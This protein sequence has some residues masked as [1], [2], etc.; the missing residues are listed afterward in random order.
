MVGL[1]G[2]GRAKY[3]TG[4]RLGTSAGLGWKGLL[5]ER[6]TH[7]EGDL[8]EVEPRD[9][10]VIV[11]LRGRLHVRRR[12]DG[13]LEHRDSGPGSV[14]LCPAGVREDMIHLYGKVRESVHLYLP[15]MPLSATAL[16]EIDADLRNVAVQYKGGFRDPLVERVARAVRAEMLDPAPGGKLLVETLAAALGVHILRQHANL[17]HSP[18]PS[19]R[20][21]LDCRRLQRVVDFIEAR[22]GEDLTI[23]ALA[24]EA[25][26]SPFHFARAFKAATG[27]A[28]HRYLLDRRI[29][30]ARVMISEDRLPLSEIANACGFSSQAHFTR[31]FRRIVGVTPGVYR[32]RVG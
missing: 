30:Q 3:T 8:G 17:E 10:E 2:I 1:A 24:N 25:C 19:V 23:E 27:T 11:Q 26:L 32:A 6:W 5:A 4:T 15:A 7:S 13:R 20:G 12:G 9:M 16:S 29:G 14:W 21:A 18:L 31:W 22:L 28:P